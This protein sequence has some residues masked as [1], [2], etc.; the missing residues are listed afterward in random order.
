MLILRFSISN[1]TIKH[2]LDVPLELCFWLSVL[3]T[4]PRG[5]CT[6]WILKLS[7]KLEIFD[8][9]S[10]FVFSAIGFLFLCFLSVSSSFMKIL[11]IRCFLCMCSLYDTTYCMALSWFVLHLNVYALPSVKPNSFSYSLNS[12]LYFRI[13]QFCNDLVISKLS[14]WSIKIHAVLIINY[15]S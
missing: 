8:W 14:F 7:T 12:V 3:P 9:L 5:V 13:W 2:L 4:I 1:A 6:R 11:E 15:C 10:V